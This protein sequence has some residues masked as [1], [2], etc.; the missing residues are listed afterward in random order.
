MRYQAKR[1]IA[2]RKK[3]KQKQNHRCRKRDKHQKRLRH[4]LYAEGKPFIAVGARLIRN[5]KQP[6]VDD[7]LGVVL[8]L[9]RQ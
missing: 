8:G 7:A 3:E 9:L 2:E 5:L 6:L 1:Q 4:S